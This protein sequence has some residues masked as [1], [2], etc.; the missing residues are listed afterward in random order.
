VTVHDPCAVRDEQA[1][2][3]AVRAL[4]RAQGL[5]I[6]EMEHHGRTTHCCGE[7]G[8]VGF[9]SPRFSRNWRDRRKT[10]AAGRRIITYCAGCVNLL[11]AITPTSHV[12]DL[13]FESRA[14]L[15]GKIRASKAPFTYWNRLRL[16]RRFKKYVKAVVTRERNLH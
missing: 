9:F 12:L 14:T 10:E 2:H 3:E 13:I 15:A 11:G 4:I 16:K 7:G 5:H 8:A 6:Q 1:I